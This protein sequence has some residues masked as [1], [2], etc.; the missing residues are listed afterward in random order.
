MCD[1]SSS[2]SSS[3][4][5][6]LSNVWVWVWVWVDAGSLMRR[7]HLHLIFSCQGR[8]GG[9]KGCSDPIDA[10]EEVSLLFIHEQ[11]Q[12]QDLS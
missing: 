1:F 10:M 4:H 11:E 9:L 5:L 3:L 2:F 7:S 12:D 6:H 8:S